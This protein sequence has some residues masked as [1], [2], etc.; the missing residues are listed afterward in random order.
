MARTDPPL[1]RRTLL[2]GGAALGAAVGAAG[3]LTACGGG[4]PQAPEAPPTNGLQPP[5]T[6]GGAGTAVAPVADVPVGGGKVFEALEI[7]VTQPSAGQFRGFSTECTHAGCQVNAVVDG[8]IDCPC[9]G[10]RFHLDGSVANGP[11]TRPLRERPVTV[12][13]GQIALG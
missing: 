11:A 9:H 5:L 10:S 2:A 13:D 4:A 6:S 12:T 8:T 7:V 1:D 3:L